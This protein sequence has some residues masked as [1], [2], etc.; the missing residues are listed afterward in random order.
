M[1]HHTTR[2]YILP[3]IVGT[4][5]S[6]AAFLSVLWFIDPFSGGVSAHFFFYLTL[7]LTTVGAFTLLG[8]L[9]R[10]KFSPAILSEQLAL[11]LRQAVLL[12]LLLSGFLILRVNH[13]LFWWVGVILILFIITVEVFFNV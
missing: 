11:S 6:L 12:A 3:L 10:K 8:I 9:L 7:F 5:L 1:I 13:L 2:T 4:I